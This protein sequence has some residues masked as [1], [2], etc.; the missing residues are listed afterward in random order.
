MKKFLL[1]T[2]FA[3]VAFLVCQEKKERNDLFLENV[4]ALSRTESSN[5]NICY[6]SS[7]VRIGYT[8]YDCGDC[9]KVYDEKGI[10]SASKCFK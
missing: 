4:E 8:Y 10:G 6:S 3:V 7:R 1:L 2:A 5:Y 9:K